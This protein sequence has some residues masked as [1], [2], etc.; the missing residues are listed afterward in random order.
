MIVT[1]TRY[2]VFVAAWLL[3]LNILLRL[4]RQ[5]TQQLLNT[6]WAQHH[7]TKPVN[8]AI[9]TILESNTNIGG[10]LDQMAEYQLPYDWVFLYSTQHRES[11]QLMQ[12]I[13]NAQNPTISTFF[14]SIRDPFDMQQIA[15]HPRMLHYDYSWQI[16]ADTVCNT[17]IDQLQYVAARDIKYGFVSVGSYADYSGT[18]SSQEQ[19]QKQKQIYTAVLD[20]I[21]QKYLYTDEPEDKKLAQQLPLE[22]LDYA[23]ASCV[24]S[25]ACEVVSLMFVRSEQYSELAEHLDLSS[26]LT[27][28]TTTTTTTTTTST[29][30]EQA[31]SNAQLLKTLALS[32][33]SHKTDIVHLP[34]LLEGAGVESNTSLSAYHESCLKK[35]RR[36]WGPDGRERAQE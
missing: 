34:S 1:V 28:I 26:T 21:T 5:W 13:I 32:V 11:M 27:T 16:N 33:F 36:V 15:W 23:N 2:T 8:G 6:H 25:A 10:L 4:D 29:S 18:S 35:F 3:G 24:F 17:S 14:E 12:S 7:R 31:S 30:Q 22:Y 9:L 19:E 20:Y